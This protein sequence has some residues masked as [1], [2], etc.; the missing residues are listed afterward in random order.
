MTVTTLNNKVLR[1]DDEICVDEI[2]GVKDLFG[3]RYWPECSRMADKDYKMRVKR[4][5]N[6]S[7]ANVPCT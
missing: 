6:M 3:L 5:V 7:K 4:F 2:A 1:V